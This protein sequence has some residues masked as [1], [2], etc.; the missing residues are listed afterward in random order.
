MLKKRDRI[1]TQFSIVM[2][3]NVRVLFKASWKCMKGLIWCIYYESSSFLQ[4]EKHFTRQQCVHSSHECVFS[5][6]RR[7]LLL[8]A[9]MQLLRIAC[10]HD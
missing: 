2:T 9:C 5:P 6:E 4:S 3:Y 10:K 1:R 8:Y 7:L